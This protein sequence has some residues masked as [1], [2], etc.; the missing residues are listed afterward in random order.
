MQE[1]RSI[2]TARVIHGQARLVGSGSSEANASCDRTI[3]A[4]TRSC[5]RR[6][7]AVCRRVKCPDLIVDLGITV[8]CV[9]GV[10]E[11]VVTFDGSLKNVVP[12][13]EVQ[14]ELWRHLPIVLHPA[15]IVML[16]IER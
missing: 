10:I 13:A 9:E 14:R 3:Q 15:S 8:R 4:S 2:R 1:I 12:D 16:R 7:A 5:S 6:D 11:L